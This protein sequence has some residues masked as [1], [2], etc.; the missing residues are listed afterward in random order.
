M[1]QDPER[2][3]GGQDTV[4]VNLSHDLDMVSIFQSLTVEAELD[5]DNIHGVLESSGIESVVERGPYPNLGV[6]VLVA[7][8]DVE[9]ART[10][11]ADALAAGP[12]AAAEAEAQS[13]K[14]Q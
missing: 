14:P 10:L 2:P 11:I 6:K 7:R 13:E 1:A 4:E 12:E 3:E 5:A 9:R 8:A